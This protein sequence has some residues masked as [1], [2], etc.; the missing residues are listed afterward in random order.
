LNPLG[1]GGVEV[2]TDPAMLVGEVL[3]CSLLTERLGFEVSSAR[4]IRHKPGRRLLAIYETAQGQ[5]LGKVRANHRAS[6]PFRL[7]TRFFA[8]GFADQAPDEIA[9]PEPVAVLEDLGVW[10]Q[11]V[12]SGQTATD[13]FTTKPISEAVWVAQQSARAAHKVH[14][15]NV[16]TRRA[17]TI[18]DELRILDRRLVEM[19]GAADISRISHLVSRIAKVREGC[20]LIAQTLGARPATGIHRDYYP[21]QL[22]VDGQRMAIVD[23]DL[24]CDGDPA[25]DIGNFLAHLTELAVRTW[26]DPRA[27]Q[28]CTD[29]FLNEYLSVAGDHNYF[30]VRVYETLSL[31][32]HIS[33]STEFADRRSL[34]E[35]LLCLTEERLCGVGAYR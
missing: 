9:V 35:T 11:R 18:N 29:A 5:L 25:V 27:L 33:L 15:A 21:D 12:V 34:T 3:N 19:L 1:L 24:Y 22:V 13:I 10:F 6:T 31:A 14:T 28:S 23:F 20:R 8:N 2:I 30:A 32:R 26:G 7:A 16:A 4:V 17:H